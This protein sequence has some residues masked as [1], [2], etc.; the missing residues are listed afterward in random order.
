MWKSGVEPLACLP[1]YRFKEEAEGVKRI[2]DIHQMSARASTF[3]LE[4]GLLLSAG[5]CV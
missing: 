4:A 3:F 2:V 5:F 1:S